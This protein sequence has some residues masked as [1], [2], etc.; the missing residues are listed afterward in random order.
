MLAHLGGVLADK[1]FD[2][3]QHQHPRFW[4]ILKRILAQSRH[5]VALAGASR[6][7]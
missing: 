6:Q 3:G 7:H 5:D 2:V 1:F 4:P